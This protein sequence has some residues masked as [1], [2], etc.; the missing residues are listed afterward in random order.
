MSAN[1]PQVWPRAGRS[2]CGEPV[3]DPT[4]STP[5]N[6]QTSSSP[7]RRRCATSS[8]TCSALLLSLSIAWCSSELRSAKSCHNRSTTEVSVIRLRGFSAPPAVCP[9]PRY[10]SAPIDKY[11]AARRALRDTTL[12]PISFSPAAGSTGCAPT[13]DEALAVVRPRRHAYGRGAGTVQ[14]R[15][16]L[17][18]GSA[19]AVHVAPSQRNV[20][21]VPRCSGSRSVEQLPNRRWRRN[22]PR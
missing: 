15:G 21:A 9:G 4:N 13:R 18:A 6:P 17:C 14:T 7:S 5:H 11:R 2:G 20:M 16:Q 10:L 22:A 19:V 1:L 12:S 8:A 3:G